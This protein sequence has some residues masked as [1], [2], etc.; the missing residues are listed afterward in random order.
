M[1]AVPKPAGFNC[2]NCGAAVAVRGFAH[3]LNVVCESCQ[4]VLD[5]RD[6]NFK[7]LQQFQERQK[8][9]P[10]IPLGSRG[11]WK[12]AV[13][14]V[15][16][17][18]QR[19]ITVEG[20][21]YSWQEYLLFNP[22][23]GF[24]YFSFYNGHWNDIEVLQSVPQAAS[25]FGARA[26]FVLDEVSYAHFQRASA[27][28]TFVLG[29][30]PWQVRVGDRV[31]ANDYVA[32]PLMLSSE[33]TGDETTWSR[34]MYTDGQEI[35]KAFGVPGAPFKPVGVFANQPS[36]YA[37][38]VKSAW[39]RYAVFVPLIIAAI[40]FIKIMS[41]NEEVFRQ[42]YSYSQN[43]VSEHSLVTPIFE[44]KGRDTN[45]EVEIRTDL[46]NNWAYFN[47]ALI[48]VDTDTAYD[49]AREVS[50]YSGRDSDGSWT[51][52]S[53]G[54]SVTLPVIPSGRYYLRIEPEM[55]PGGSGQMSY[56]V[57]L[58]HGVLGTGWLWALLGVLLIPPLW[59]TIRAS[60]FESRR[61]AESDYAPSGSDDSGGDDE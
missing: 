42:R 29:E 34:G 17:F 9:D 13:Y 11:K 52:G 33:S 32:P 39:K 2:P 31:E 44:L 30:F 40:L 18:Q 16:G 6:P 58:K 12:G 45:A 57:R 3:S 61:M 15:I 23:E 10:Q 56:E 5:A 48:N 59:I 1:S 60:V 36:P 51:E 14:E 43:S 35:W 38:T 53:A 24:R 50:Y 27:E 25:S 20:V 26:K 46:S 22:F 4:S 41:P 47:L 55:D 28:T 37:G 54:D 49:F 7:V 19:T 8:V 21:E